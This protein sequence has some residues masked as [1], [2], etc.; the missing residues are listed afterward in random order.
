MRVIYLF[1]FIA[2]GCRP[3]NKIGEL[4][5]VPVHRTLEGTYWVLEELNGKVIKAEEGQ[6]SPFVFYLNEGKAVRGFA[7]CNSFT[8]TFTRE[9]S[10]VSAKLAST[11]MF[12]EGKMDL[13]SEFMNVLGAPYKFQLE[14]NHLLLKNKGD[15]VAAFHAEVKTSN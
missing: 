15:L 11:R 10:I 1:I 12:C 2:I 8:G 13:E 3:S 7:G 6:K 5:G 9:G 14:E 4:V